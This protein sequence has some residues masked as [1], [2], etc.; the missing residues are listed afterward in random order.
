LAVNGKSTI[1]RSLSAASAIRSGLESANR[2]Q[3]AAHSIKSYPDVFTI[4]PLRVTINTAA[5][6]ISGFEA[7]SILFN[8]YAIHCEMATSSTLV[9]LIG[10]G[11]TPEVE[12]F[13]QALNQL[14]ERDLT[15][16]QNLDLPAAGER[17]M[18]VRDAYFSLT[19]V[20][21]AKSAVGR[22]SADSVAAYPPGIPNLLPG[23]IITAETISF[24][25]ATATAPFG[26]VRGGATKDMSAFRVVS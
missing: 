1:S 22:I 5:G 15:K 11:A 2:Y 13:L 23:E 21:G 3:D 12:I 20:V 10:A 25:Q 24:L 7:R 4:D 6:N 16:N 14:P 9:A 18:T 8:D 26:H 17:K 19:E